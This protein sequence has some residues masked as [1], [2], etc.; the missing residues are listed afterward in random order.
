MEILVGYG[1]G[2]KMQRLI[3][4][5]WDNAELVCR[6]NGVFGKPFKAGRG[7][8]QG[9]P[10]SPRIFNVMVDAIVREWLRQVLGDEVACSGIGAEIQVFLA[11]FYADDGLIQSRDPVIL[12]SSFNI[13]VKLFEH[14]GL[15][16]NTTKTVTIVCVPGKIWTPL[17]REV[18]DNCRQGFVTPLAEW[19]RRRVQCEHCG[20]HLSAALLPTHVENLHG[21]FHLKVLNRVLTEEE[22]MLPTTHVAYLS[23]PINRLFCPYPGCNGDLASELNLRRHFAVRHPADLVSTPRNGCLLKCNRCGLQ[24]TLEQCMHGHKDTKQC[25][26]GEARR[27]Q[28]KAAATSIKALE[29]R[30]TSYNEELERVE[31]FKYLGRLLAFNDNDT[32]AICPNLMKARKVWSWVSCVLRVENAPPPCLWHILQRYGAGSLTI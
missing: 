10:V 11:A 21:I 28:H 9:G 18:Y 4:F 6:A 12:Q 2:P 29:E 5:F 20:A 8:P 1:V 23:Q 13:L 27:V 30:F 17:L 25:E 16:T 32:Q 15:C 26:E 7:V 19:K 24:V 31:V 14:V 3:Q 22:N